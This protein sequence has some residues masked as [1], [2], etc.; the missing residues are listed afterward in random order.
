MN[1]YILFPG[2]T[3]SCAGCFTSIANVFPLMGSVGVPM[4]TIEA[5]LVSAPEMG[6]DALSTTP[7]RRD[8]CTWKYIILW[9]S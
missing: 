8:L 9:L 6:C 4:T 7:K 1:E 3:V 5:R 2:L